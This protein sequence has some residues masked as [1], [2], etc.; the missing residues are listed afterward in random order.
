M[1]AITA[2]ERYQTMLKE[3]AGWSENMDCT[4]EAIAIACDVP[5]AY[6]HMILDNAGRKRN[7][8]FA[9]IQWLMEP[10]RVGNYIVKTR[11]VKLNMSLA[12]VIRNLQHGRFIVHKKCH[13]FNVIDGMVY[14]RRGIAMNTKVS[15]VWE[16]IPAV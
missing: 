1:R 9:F 15:Q 5:Y 4:V 7:C 2:M 13:V 6:A 8:P 10:R 14:D 3:R 16:V 12:H 11:F